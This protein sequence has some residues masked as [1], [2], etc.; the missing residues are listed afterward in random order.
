MKFAKH[1][2]HAEPATVD[3]RALTK[4]ILH[5]SLGRMGAGSGTRLASFFRGF[6]R[7]ASP[8]SP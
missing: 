6:V 2:Q 4:S 8:S 1:G 3:N 7:T 5:R